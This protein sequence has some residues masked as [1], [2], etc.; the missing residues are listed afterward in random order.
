M[1]NHH[2]GL[3]THF[4]YCTGLSERRGSRDVLLL[5]KPGRRRL[6]WFWLLATRLPQT[7]KL[8]AAGVSSDSIMET[9]QTPPPL[10]SY[11]LWSGALRLAINNE[12][13]HSALWTIAF[14]LAES[15]ES[16]VS[17]RESVSSLC[18]A[19]ILHSP[20]AVQSRANTWYLLRYDSSV[21]AGMSLMPFATRWCKCMEGVFTAQENK[22][23][24]VTAEKKF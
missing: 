1:T 24:A 6:L 19:W 18:H 17:R 10:L 23:Q 11:F 8:A 2:P 5:C 12:C 22:G 9:G 13:G 14:I 4:A 7:N 21:L 15:A 16:P 3:Q 20:R